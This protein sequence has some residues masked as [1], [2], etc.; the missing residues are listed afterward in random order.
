MFGI[1]IFI[2][3]FDEEEK[4]VMTAMSLMSITMVSTSPL[5]S[6]NR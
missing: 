1:Y 2:K 4:T 6:A 3:T 5:L